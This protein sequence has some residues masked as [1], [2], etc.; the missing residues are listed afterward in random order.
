MSLLDQQPLFDSGPHAFDVGG[1]ELRH[2]QTPS[3]DPAARGAHL[4]ARGVA[5]RAIH[6]HGHLLA[7]STDQLTQQIA[8]IEARL[9]GRP[10]ELVDH[11]GRVWPSVVLVAFTPDAGGPVRLGARYRL[12]YTA[13]YLQP[14]P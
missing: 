2:D 5:P 12:S 1:L 8:L 10:R 11:L 13:R 14:L 7:D 3:S 4:R 6:Q 9:D